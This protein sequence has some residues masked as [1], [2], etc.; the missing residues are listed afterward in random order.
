MALFGRRMREPVLNIFGYILE[1][2]CLEITL[3]FCNHLF[4]K[5]CA[6]SPFLKSSERNCQMLGFCLLTFVRKKP[7]SQGGCAAKGGLPLENEAVYRAV[8]AG[9]QVLA[10]LALACNENK[11]LYT[12]ALSHTLK[13]IYCQC[14][15]LPRTSGHFIAHPIDV[16]LRLVKHHPLSQLSIFFRNPAH[17]DKWP[18]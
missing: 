3:L 8:N 16:P 6:K 10:E 12:A 1:T 7:K 9:K 2:S 15:Q 11:L 14:L 18:A 5:C 17:L 13:Q 4:M